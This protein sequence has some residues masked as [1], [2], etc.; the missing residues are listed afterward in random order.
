MD[1]LACGPRP[2]LGT[3]AF[4]TIRHGDAQPEIHA[5]TTAHAGCF[6][7][8]A[9]RTAHPQRRSLPPRCT[10]DEPASHGLQYCPLGQYC[11]QGGR[12]CSWDPSCAT[13][14][15]APWLKETET[16]RH[17]GSAAQQGRDQSR[18]ITA[19]GRLVEAKAERPLSEPESRQQPGGEPGVLLQRVGLAGSWPPVSPRWVSSLNPLPGLYAGTQTGRRSSRERLAQRHPRC[20]LP[21]RTS[22]GYSAVEAQTHLPDRHRCPGSRRD[23]H[24][25]LGRRADTSPRV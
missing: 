22:R 24:R 19:G 25:A 9:P 12:Q 14:E 23:T 2:A 11:P 20:R 3:E 17:W 10:S 13:G 7:F 4:R 8:R 15:T 21:P 6:K 1:T 5:S 18:E 16:A